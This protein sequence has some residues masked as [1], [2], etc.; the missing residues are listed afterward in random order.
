MADKLVLVNPFW[1]NNHLF[2]V[3]ALFICCFKLICTACVIDCK[4]RPQWHHQQILHSTVPYGRGIWEKESIIG[5]QWFQKNPNPL[6]HRSVGNS[7]CLV[8]YWNGGPSGW[9]FSVPT[10]HQWWILFISHTRYQPMG[11]IKIDSFF[12]MPRFLLEWWALGLGFFC[13]HWTPMMDSIY[14]TYPIPTH[15]NDKNWTAACLKTSDVIVM[16]KWRHECHVTSQHAQNFLEDFIKIK[17]AVF[18]YVR[19]RFFLLTIKYTIKYD[20]RLSLLCKPHDAKQWP[21]GQFFLSHHYNHDGSSYYFT[22]WPK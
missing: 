20:H 3:Y 11:M 8:S 7:A 14:L 16:L 10:E 2:I 12:G 15:G 6:V 19:A 17:N 5:V 9:D 4:H 22:G 21:L 18:N 1:W 13:P